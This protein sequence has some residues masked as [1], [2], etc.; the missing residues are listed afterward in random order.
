MY[1][2]IKSI[3]NLKN[4]GPTQC[5]VSIPFTKLTAG[6]ILITKKNCR[7]FSIVKKNVGVILKY[8]AK[9]WELGLITYL[10]H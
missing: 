10:T 5:H 8:R 4:N 1:G 7:A 2:L 3:F 9:C 6:L